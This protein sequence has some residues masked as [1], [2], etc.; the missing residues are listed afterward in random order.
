[1]EEA[2]NEEMKKFLSSLSEGIEF[3]QDNNDVQPKT[4]TTTKDSNIK[5][6]TRNLLTNVS[7][8]GYKPEDVEKTNLFIDVLSFLKQKLNPTGLDRKLEILLE[9]DYVKMIWDSCVPHK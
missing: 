8:R 2:E 3:F 4:E 1:M 9:R 6:K 5:V 7:Y